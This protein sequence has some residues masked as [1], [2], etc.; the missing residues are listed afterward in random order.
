[1]RH[2]GQSQRQIGNLL[3]LRKEGRERGKRRRKRM[4]ARPRMRL[5]MH[6]KNVNQCRAGLGKRKEKRAS[7][8]SAEGPAGPAGTAFCC[9][10]LSLLTI[11]EHKHCIQ[12]VIVEMIVLQP[13]PWTETG[14]DWTA[15]GPSWKGQFSAAAEGSSGFP[16]TADQFRP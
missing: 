10:L 14:L 15:K 16:G 1:M 5:N 9:V 4:E 7:T 3:L 12:V 11:I 8:A 13:N 2:Y 6:A